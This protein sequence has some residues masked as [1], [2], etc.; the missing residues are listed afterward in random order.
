LFSVEHGAEGCPVVDS[1]DTPT[2]TGLF[3]AFA[4]PIFAGTFHLAVA[5]GTF[6][7]QPFPAVQPICVIFKATQCVKG[8][9]F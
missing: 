4:D 3:H 6:L 9:D 2:G 8:N 1:S 7:R 5:D